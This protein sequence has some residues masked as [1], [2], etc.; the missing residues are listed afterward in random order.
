MRTELT[1]LGRAGVALRTS[2]QRA[3]LLEARETTDTAYVDQVS[4]TQY[5]AFTYSDG[6]KVRISHTFYSRREADLVLRRKGFRVV[7]VTAQ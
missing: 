2:G 5:E 7:Q 1:A 3:S 4:R 6:R